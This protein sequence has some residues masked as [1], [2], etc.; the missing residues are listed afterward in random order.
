MASPKA[1]SCTVVTPRVGH[2]WEQNSCPPKNP[3]QDGSL[4]PVGRN[5]MGLPPWGDL[6]GEGHGTW[7]GQGQEPWALE[8]Q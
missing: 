4:A 1:T 6:K 7:Q 2:S 5:Q 8:A 3:S